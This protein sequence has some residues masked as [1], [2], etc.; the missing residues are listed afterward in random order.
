MAVLSISILLYLFFYL[1]SVMDPFTLRISIYL[2]RFLCVRGSRIVLFWVTRRGQNKTDAFC[3]GFSLYMCRMITHTHTNL[4]SH[5][6][7]VL[8][9]SEMAR[10]WKRDGERVRRRRACA[11]QFFLYSC[12]SSITLSSGRRMLGLVQTRTSPGSDVTLAHNI[13]KPL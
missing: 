6:K 8:G 1:F 5:A 7:H 12:G 13:Y 10:E 11:V 2:I 3:V 9:G 4:M